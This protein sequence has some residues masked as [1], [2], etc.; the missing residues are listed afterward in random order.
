MAS[1]VEEIRNLIPPGAQYSGT[2]WHNF[3]CPACG[4]KRRRGGILFTDDGGFKYSCFNGGCDYN[5]RPT[6]WS[7]E[8]DGFGGRVRQLY[9]MLGGD[10]RRIPIELL[11]RRRGKVFNK[12]GSVTEEK[13]LDVVY[14]FEE[15]DLP[16]GSQL[17]SDAVKDE[18]PEA[19]EV[20][21][22]LKKRAVP[23]KKIR[24]FEFVWSPEYPYHLIIP[25]VHNDAIVGY[26][27]RSIRKSGSGKDRFIQRSPSDYIFNQHLLR[28]YRARY[29]FVVEAPLDAITLECLAVRNDRMTTRQ[30]NL[31]IT[32][33]KDIVLIPDLKR[34][35]WSG[36]YETAMKHKWYLSIPGWGPGVGDVQQSVSHSGLLYTIMRIMQ[37]TTRNYRKAKVLLN[38]RST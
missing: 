23:P 9:Q 8:M 19:F 34:G 30:E 18:I 31:L 1:I 11:M 33:G 27:G 20:L 14:K 17:L 13:P 22:Y 26:V 28:T 3:N 25:Y 16:Q 37:G 6:G 35:E 2:G 29:L 12:D 36:F 5:I 10:I 32:S 24:E 7:P 15:C 4:D 21:E 38:S